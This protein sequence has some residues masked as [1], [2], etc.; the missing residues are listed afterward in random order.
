MVNL[1]RIADRGAWVAVCG[2]L[3][4]PT[5]SKNIEASIMV[6]PYCVKYRL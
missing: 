4:A 2:K 1:H 5:M 6:D 3:I